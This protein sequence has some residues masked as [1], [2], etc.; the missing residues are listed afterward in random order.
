MSV[1]GFLVNGQVQKYDYDSLDNLPDDTGAGSFPVIYNV[2]TA[3]EITQAL[4]KNQIPILKDPTTG[5]LYYLNSSAELNG[6]R[7]YIFVSNQGNKMR[8]VEVVGNTWGIFSDTILA[9]NTSP[10]FQ[11]IPKAPTAPNGTNNTQLATTAFVHQEIMYGALS[12]DLKQAL[13]QIASKVAYIDADG[14]TYYNDL[15]N[16]LYPHDLLWIEA[17]FTQGSAIIYD[18]DSLNDLKQYLTVVA[19]YSGGNTETLS[20]SDYTLSGNLLS[21]V[22]EITVAYEGFTDTFNVVVTHMAGYYTIVNNLTGCTTNNSATSIQENTTYTA[23]ITASAGYTLSGA[24]ATITMGGNILTGVFSNGT[25]SIPNVTGDLVITVVASAITVSSISAVY[26]QTGTVYNTDTLD[27]LKTD[28]VVTATYSDSSTQT[29]PAADYT[30]SGTLTAGTSTITVSYGGKTTTFTV[31]V[32]EGGLPAEYQQVEW[33]ESQ[34]GPMIDTGV[35]PTANSEIQCGAQ[36][37]NDGSSNKDCIF[38]STL[39]SMMFLQRNTGMTGNFGGASCTTNAANIKNSLHDIVL[40]ASTFMVDEIA[41]TLSG[42]VGD[43]SNSNHI[44]LFGYRDTNSGLYVHNPWARISYFRVYDSGSL[45]CNLIPC[46]RKSDRIIGMFDLVSRTFLTNINTGTF[47]C[48]PEDVDPAVRPIPSEYQ[49]VRYVAAAVAG[50]AID[51][52]NVLNENCEI[53]AGMMQFI[54]V[55]ASASQAIFG[56][57]DPSVLLFPYGSTGSTLYTNY[58]RQ[59]SVTMADTNIRNGIHNIVLNKSKFQLDGVTKAT[60]SGTISEFNNPNRHLMLFAWPSDDN[61]TP[62]RATANLCSYCKVYD[63]GTL[64]SDLVPCYR[65]SDGVVGMYDLVKQAFR[66][67]VGTGSLTKGSNVT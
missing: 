3:S 57:T 16:A 31:T 21:G 48:G 59:T 23:T 61:N 39:P 30:L 52:F 14:Q 54:P 56:S 38:C 50:P 1:T 43:F 24:T 37:L 45:V 4:N 7:M 29:I 5:S 13:L 28:L 6:N 9:L 25:I 27:S 33:I 46:Y 41:Y 2:T 60:F 35:T 53:Q 15:E 40:S 64:A 12:E 62:D 49:Q 44:W 42:T 63:N 19:T 67:N 18:T 32:T 26:T 36:L 17:T 65:K 8:Q 66:V 22:S 10:T 34:Y 11:G 47:D 20:D 58:A 51:T 55:N